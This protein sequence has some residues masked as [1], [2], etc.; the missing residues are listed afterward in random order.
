VGSITYPPEGEGRLPL[1]KHVTSR[2]GLLA[3]GLVLAASW[4]APAPA[5]AT[6]VQGVAFEAQASTAARV[7]VGAVRA[8]ESR[9]SPRA[10]RYFETLVTFA[11]EE[12]VAG[13]PA[14][15]LVVRL[16]GGTVGD[17]RQEVVGM[18][19]FAVGERYVVFL[20][21]EQSPPLISPIVGFNQGLYRV[22]RVGDGDV[23]RD[24]LGDPL[25]APAAARAGAGGDTPLGDFL[26]AVRG[27]R[28]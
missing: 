14:T 20:E 21:P 13:A 23:V 6:V 3:A 9:P 8:I 7:F 28:R 18:P 16:S 1:A 12:T 22:V 11:V 17:V 24:R 2:S 27:A 26:E 25:A 19:E 10:P 5:G 4:S 15:T